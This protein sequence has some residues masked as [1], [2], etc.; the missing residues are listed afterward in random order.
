MSKCSCLVF[1]IDRSEKHPGLTTNIEFGEWFK[2]KGIVIG[3]PDKAIK[4]EYLKIRLDTLKIPYYTTL[5]DTLNA[6]LKHLKF[7]IDTEDLYF[8]SDTHFNQQRTLELSKRPFPNLKEMD[9]TMMSNWNKLVT[10]KDTVIHAGDIGNLDTLPELLSNLNYKT[11]ILITGNYERRELDKYKAIIKDFPNVIAEDEGYHLTEKNKD[12]KSINFFVC[13]EP[14]SPLYHI[15]K[16]YFGNEKFVT[17]FGHIHGRSFAKRNGFDI[18][19]DYHQ[20]TPLSLDDVMWFVNAMQ[21][22]DEN[23]YTDRV[24]ENKVVKTFMEYLHDNLQVSYK[25]NQGGSK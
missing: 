18:G 4:N 5:E 24:K 8:T 19:T 6:A 11:L 13:H 25:N 7:K 23:V 21:Y 16:E 1:W 3:M 17:L 14:V 22:W 9:L 10:I 15:A 20:Y 12:G 2:K